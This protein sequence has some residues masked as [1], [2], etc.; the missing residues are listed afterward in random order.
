MTERDVQSAI[1][2]M[3]KQLGFLVYHTQYALGS[4]PG[5]PDLVIAGHGRVFFWE[6][7]GPRGKLSEHQEA[8]LDT[9]AFAGMTANVIW[10]DDLDDALTSLMTAYQEATA[11]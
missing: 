6:I 11:A 10:P 5:F 4:A 1:V 7:K 2:R 9:L 8:W 3:A